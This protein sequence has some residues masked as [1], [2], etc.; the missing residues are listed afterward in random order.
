MRLNELKFKKQLKPGQEYRL[1][2]PLNDIMDFIDIHC[3]DAV[4]ASKATHK[5]LFR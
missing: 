4:A 1:H 5:V 3:S 2:R